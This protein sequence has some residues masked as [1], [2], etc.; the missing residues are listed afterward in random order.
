M[1]GTISIR[2]PFVKFDLQGKADIIGH[3]VHNINTLILD[4]PRT[5]LFM[6]S[7]EFLPEAI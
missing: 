7:F 3:G 1:A 2:V 6:W 5:F 4:I